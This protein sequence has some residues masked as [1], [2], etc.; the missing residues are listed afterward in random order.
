M[1]QKKQKKA[2]PRFKGITRP[3][4]YNAIVWAT[5][6]ALIAF[7]LLFFESNFL[8][9][10]QELNLFQH[11]GLFFKHHMVVPGG[12]LTYLGTFLTQFF[13]YPWLGVLLLTGCWLLLM[14]LVKRAFHI[15]GKWALLLLAP[16]VFLLLTIVDTGY[17]LYILKLHGHFFVATLGALFVSVLLWIY[18]GL[19]AKHH[20]RGI[21]LVLT[22]VVGYPLAGCYGL[23]A[24]LL[25]AVMSWRM[26]SRS[27]SIVYSVLALLADSTNVERAGYS[28]SE[29]NVAHAFDE[30]FKGCDRRIIVTTFASNVD[31]I[32]TVINTAARYGRKVAI[33]GRS[34]E[35]VVQLSVPLT[36]ECNIGKNW[37]EAH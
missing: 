3:R 2:T 20:L 7:A 28:T 33:T 13:Y 10:A 22:A 1:K 34:M 19:P 37:L 24:T 29:R 12:M 5:G 25:M 4:L 9:K 15:P 11:T 30:L 27:V 17:W 26:E 6:L 31:R 18:Q 8:W 16:V 35:N 36:V 14:F 32:Q 23:A 21:F